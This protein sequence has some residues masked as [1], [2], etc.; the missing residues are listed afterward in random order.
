MVLLKRV[1]LIVVVILAI[2]IAYSFT[3]KAQSV[4]T[5][6]DA[7][8]IVLEDLKSDPLF[9]A[10]GLYSVYSIEY[11]NSSGQWEV[12][13]KI[14][15]SPHSAC[16]QVYLRDYKLL[17]ISP[18]LNKQVVKDCTANTPLALP[19]EAIIAS[20]D[21]IQVKALSSPQACGY[22]LPLNPVDAAEY[23]PFADYAQ[24]R[25]FADSLQSNA[26]F[27]TEW[28]SNQ[29]ILRIALDENANV[30]SVQ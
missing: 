2:A 22:S 12:K 13:T 8:A 14:T 11:L 20:K 30:L 3:S 27:V 7:K 17:P 9:S 19:E 18:S 4:A 5:A 16:P 24:L 23:C 15:L 29:T 6:A 25:Q 21:L 10:N 28:R 1:A 26:R